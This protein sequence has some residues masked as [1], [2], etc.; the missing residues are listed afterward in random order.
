MQKHIAVDL[1]AESGRIIVGVVGEIEIVHRFP[2]FPVRVGNSL[3]WDVLA[4]FAEIKHGLRL[5]FERNPGEIASIGVDTWGVDFGLFDSTGQ[6]V[7]NPYHYRDSRTDGVPDELFRRVP[8]EEVYRATGIQ[9]MQ[10]NTL[11]QL[12]AFARSNPDLY[13]ASSHLLFMPDLFTYWLTGVMRNEYTIATTSQL[14]DA[15]A[16]RW[17]LDLIR[18]LRIESKL[19]GEVVM[20]GTVIGP[21]SP[22]VAAEIGAGSEVLV[23]APA[24]HD[25]ACAVAAVPA[26]GGADYAYVSSGTWSLLG[27]ESP[28]PI[29]SEKSFHYNFTNEGAADGGIRF[30]KNIM[31]LWIVQECKR[32]WDAEGRSYSYAE[33]TELAEKNGPAGF[34]IDPDDERFLKPGITGGSMPERVRAWCSETG[35]SAPGD[36]GRTVR[37][38]LESL[39][40]TYARNIRMV[41]EI[42]GRTIAELYIIGG[43]SQNSLLCRLA[44]DATGIPVMAGPVEAT[45]IGNIMVQ[46]IALGTIASIAEGRALVRRTCDVKRYEPAPR[47]Y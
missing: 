8:R 28:A 26:T 9:I 30:L 47:A 25:T 44:A 42:S 20:P 10:I 3:Y 38:V 7:T 35:Q 33:L 41:T 5:A 4:M 36:P 13:R 11:Y 45:A 39:A 2:N 27:I 43:G 1:G 31:G 16:K 14:F 18:R 23:V 46:Q 19:F 6:L 21:L 29:I 17:A 34:V 12:T 37:G 15:Q 32:A 40:E 22:S 24:C